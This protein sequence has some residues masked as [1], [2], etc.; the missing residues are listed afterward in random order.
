LWVGLASAAGHL[1]VTSANLGLFNQFNGISQGGQ[2]PSGSAGLAC[3]ATA[4]EAVTMGDDR[5]C[6]V[7]AVP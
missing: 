7:G 6:G 2:S 1:T 4:R 5:Q 3:A